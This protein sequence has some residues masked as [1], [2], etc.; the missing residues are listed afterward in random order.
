MLSGTN[1]GA[2][3]HARICSQRRGGREPVL[4]TQR[5]SV[6]ISHIGITD[7]KKKSGSWGTSGRRGRS[8]LPTFRD[9]S[10]LTGTEW[11]RRQGGNKR[12]CL[13]GRNFPPCSWEQAVKQSSR[14]WTVRESEIEKTEREFRGGGTAH[15]LWTARRM[16]TGVPTSNGLGQRW[17]VTRDERSGTVG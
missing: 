1:T 9:L 6:G 17:P 7:G 13:D 14:R 10:G 5:K 2:F 16:P 11:E 4:S 15:L 3:D 8:Y 12:A